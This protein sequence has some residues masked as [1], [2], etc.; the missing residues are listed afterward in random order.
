MIDGIAAA[1]EIFAAMPRLPIV[2]CTV[3][4]TDVLERESQESGIRAVVDK[5]DAGTRLVSV[6]ENLLNRE[7]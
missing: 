2:L 5:N 1:R 3:F 4:S 6:V 7:L